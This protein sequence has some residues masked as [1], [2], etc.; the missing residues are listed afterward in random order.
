MFLMN[1]DDDM[2]CLCDIVFFFSGQFGI[3]LIIYAYLYGPCKIKAEI[4]VFK[5]MGQ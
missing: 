1:S 3:S 4:I 2:G 5:N